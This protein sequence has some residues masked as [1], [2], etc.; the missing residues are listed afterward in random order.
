M[1][2]RF[3]KYLVCSTKVICSL[4]RTQIQTRKEF[5]FFLCFLI[6]FFSGNC[7]R[8]WC[9]ITALIFKYIQVNLFQK[10]LFLHQLFNP[11]YDKRL[12]IG[13]P[14]QYMKT[15]SSERQE[16]MFYTQIVF[17]F[18]FDIQNNL[19]TQHVLLMF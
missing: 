4:W 15:T 9:T 7:V 8:I 12:S 13:L 6:V 11:Q 10:H 5:L 18:S 1:L 3:Y 14:A 17:C 19:C 16:N 2:V